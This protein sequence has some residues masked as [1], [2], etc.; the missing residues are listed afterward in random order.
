MT[1]RNLR[2]PFALCGELVLSPRAK[3]RVFSGRRDPT[4]P[5]RNSYAATLGRAST[6][7]HRVLRAVAVNRKTPLTADNIPFR[8]FAVKST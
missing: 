8:A 5:S 4:S 6:S 1:V 7:T 2:L 3:R